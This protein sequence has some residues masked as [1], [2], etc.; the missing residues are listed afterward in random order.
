MHACSVWHHNVITL[1]EIRSEV[2]SCG[3]ASVHVAPVAHVSSRTPLM[4][5]FP[6][7]VLD[8]GCLGVSKLPDAWESLSSRMMH[9]YAMCICRSV[10]SPIVPNDCPGV[11]KLPDDAHIR[12]VHLPIGYKSDCAQRLPGPIYWEAVQAAPADARCAQPVP[13]T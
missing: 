8:P 7:S 4:G 5:A 6:R 12:H 13:K 3:S 9:T 10:I 1:Q 11:S 2:G